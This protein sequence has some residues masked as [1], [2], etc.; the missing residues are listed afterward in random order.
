MRAPRL[1]RVRPN[2]GGFSFQGPGLMRYPPPDRAS[3]TAKKGSL[4]TSISFAAQEPCCSLILWPLRQH[5]LLGRLHPSTWPI[6]GCSRFLGGEVM[7]VNGERLPL[8]QKAV[9]F[10]VQ[11]LLRPTSLESWE[12][13][14][15]GEGSCLSGQSRAGRRQGTEDMTPGYGRRRGWVGGWRC[16]A[17]AGPQAE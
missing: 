2:G 6:L 1:P 13:Q 16:K 7:G 10:G 3:L 9:A 17:R 8:Q 4:A 5:P 14:R 15:G 11:R 12:T